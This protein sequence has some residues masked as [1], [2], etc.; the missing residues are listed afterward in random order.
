MSAKKAINRRTTNLNASFSV[1]EIKIKHGDT[2]ARRK[3]WRRKDEKEETSIT[4]SSLILSKFSPCFFMNYD[5]S[6]AN[7][8]TC[9]YYAISTYTAHTTHTY[10]Q[11]LINTTFTDYLHRSHFTHT[12]IFLC[13]LTVLSFNNL[14]YNFLSRRD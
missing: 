11:T 4:V 3:R 6:P 9:I 2:E 12:L 14:C 8:K 5:Y 1:I 10:S 7:W 13:H